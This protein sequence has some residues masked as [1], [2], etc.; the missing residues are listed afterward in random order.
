MRSMPE[1]PWIRVS[2]FVRQHTHDV[3]NDLN[4]LDL[5]VALLT[6]LVSDP[7]ACESLARIRT[8]IRESATR[9][10]ELSAR[11]TEPRP[12]LA[13]L[14][15]SDLF[16]IWKEQFGGLNQP[17]NVK[18]ESRLSEQALSVDAGL[19]AIALRELLTN[20]SKFSPGSEVCALGYEENRAALYQLKEVKET[21]VAPEAWSEVPLQAAQR[22]GYGLG[23]WYVRRIVEAHGGTF[24]QSYDLGSRTLGSVISLPLT[25]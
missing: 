12:M 23:L 2:S 21:P 22:S 16:E 13:R 11:F 9:L 1:L 3:R 20:A 17:L 19:L 18:W 6:D 8:Q 14:A 4:S 15:A 10:K 25:A 7:E 5:E 24:R